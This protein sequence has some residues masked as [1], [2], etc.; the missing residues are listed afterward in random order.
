MGRLED[1]SNA[2]RAALIAAN[3][4]VMVDL[5]RPWR[6]VESDLNSAIQALALELADMRRQGK[7]ITQ[8]KLLQLDRMRDLLQQLQKSLN[9][10]AT[11]AA[12][13]INAHIR[14][15]GK[16]GI[17]SSVRLI[18]ALGVPAN[19]IFD[20]PE[21]ILDDVAKSIRNNKALATLLNRAYPIAAQGIVNQLSGGIS[22]GVNP[23]ALASQILRQGAAQ[24]L[25]HIMLVARDQGNRSWR[26]TG[27]RSMAA[28][29]VDEYRRTAA[30]QDRTCIA[31]LALDGTIYKVNVIMPL[32]PQCRCFLVPIVKGFP[33]PDIQTGKDWLASLPE[34][35]QKTILGPRRFEAF[36]GGRNLEDMIAIEDSGEWGESTKIK[37]LR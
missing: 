27:R 35:R 22:A 31:C 16:I 32:H 2:E 34:A 36:K 25:E 1:I 13:I 37:P 33:R 4:S 14:A 20:V 3:K 17:G 8:E 23:R 12:P 18:Q 11:E 29:G 15:T 7:P 6:D 9:R 21:S 30:K 5:A 26:E 28:N 24:G 19:Q 10:Y